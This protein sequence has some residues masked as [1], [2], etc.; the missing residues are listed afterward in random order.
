[1]RFYQFFEARENNLRGIKDFIDNKGGRPFKDLFGDKDRFLVKVYN[2]TLSKAIKKVEYLNI[3]KFD[4]KKRTYEGTPVSTFLKKRKEILLASIPEKEEALKEYKNIYKQDLTLLRDQII[5]HEP[6]IE[7]YSDNRLSVKDMNRADLGV[8]NPKDLEGISM[9]NWTEKDVNIYMDAIFDG[10]EQGY[11]RWRPV[12]HH[13]VSFNGFYR[14]MRIKPQME[15]QQLSEIK[16]CINQNNIYYYLLFTRHPIDVLR[17][18]DHKGISSCHRLNGGAYEHCAISDAK[19]AGGVV[20]LIKG[21]DGKKV[22]E[23]LQDQE[24]FADK[25]RD[26]GGIV[27]IG[28]TRIRCFVD[29][30][31]GE[32]FAVLAKYT[33]EQHYGVFTEDIYNVALDYIRKNQSIFNNK[34]DPDYACKYIVMAGGDYT[35]NATPSG[36]MNRFFQT[37]DYD[38][39]IKFRDSDNEDGEGGDDYA[40]EMRDIS[41]SWNRTFNPLGASIT[42]EFGG[43]TIEVY[44][45]YTRQIGWDQVSDRL[46][47][48]KQ[49]NKT[50]INID[51]D[52]FNKLIENKRDV[53]QDQ[54][55]DLIP[56]WYLQDWGI[57]IYSPYDVRM[58]I[59]FY[60][61]YD[62]PY[63]AQIALGYINNGKYIQRMQEYVDDTI[64]KFL[65]DNVDLYITDE[66]V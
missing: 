7:E 11:M 36:L 18:S 21:S 55:E 13:R 15:I 58:S 50:D 65:G 57:N 32:D 1:M 26:I 66:I 30:K 6:V 46:K 19:N 34:P 8:F 41:A 62:D 33:K 29:T 49:G 40:E 60:D 20:Y 35:D 24:V 39:C 37:N 64:A 14:Q 61:T 44:I 51:Y 48:I 4:W 22:S 23:N 63:G 52:K 54:I 45:S 31:T 56:S 12:E 43:N 47:L 53:L 25:D 59:I 2:P 5:M 17:M 28:R 10:K 9:N 38:D 42:H 16:Q 3:D 27:P